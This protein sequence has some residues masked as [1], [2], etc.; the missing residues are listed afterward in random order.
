[1]ENLMKTFMVSQDQPIIPQLIQEIQKFNLWVLGCLKNG[2]K[3]LVGH[4]DMYPF[5]F[6]MESFH[7]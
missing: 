5:I 6:F 4:I 2:P 1:M 3:T 7:G